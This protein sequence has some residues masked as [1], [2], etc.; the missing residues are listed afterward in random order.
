[1]GFWNKLGKI[2]LQAAPYI[3]APFTAG[4]SLYAIPATQKLGQKWAESDAKKA[5]EKGLAPSKFDKY[6]GMASNV[7]G[8]ASGTGA[9]GKFGSAAYTGAKAASAAG[10]ASKLA[11]A[12]QTANKLSNWQNAIKM[13][14]QTASMVA[15]GSP[16]AGDANYTNGPGSPQEGLGGWQGALASGISG[17]MNSG[18]GSNEQAK[19]AS[20]L[21]PSTLPAVARPSSVRDRLNAGRQQAVR[22]QP[23]RAGYQTEIGENDQIVTHDMPP[24]YSDVQPQVISPPISESTPIADAV[25]GTRRARRRNQPIQE[26]VQETQVEQ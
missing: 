3:A 6:L 12:G 19:P 16:Y 9:L 23:F 7:A 25:R 24:I 14:G 26:A 4:A 11:K 5:A 17:I 18:G 8:F 1:M 2:A 10:T 15:G 22:N 13:G 21:A 20:G